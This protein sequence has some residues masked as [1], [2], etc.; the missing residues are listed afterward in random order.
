MK[1]RRLVFILLLL[2]L[3]CGGSEPQP[4]PDLPEISR[5]PLTPP[6]PPVMTEPT[7]AALPEPET[8]EPLTRPPDRPPA[9]VSA[10]SPARAQDPGL[11]VPGETLSP[12]PQRSD[13]QVITVSFR[14]DIEDRA[15]M[16]PLAKARMLRR[17]QMMG[18]ASVEN[19]TVIERRCGKQQCVLRLQGAAV[20]EG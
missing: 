10:P 3:A 20:R 5:D 1:Q 16:Y 15:T 19:I 17:A 4:L 18:Y 2:A 6:P 14:S 7:A 13:Q 9:A 12:S 8:E 11:A